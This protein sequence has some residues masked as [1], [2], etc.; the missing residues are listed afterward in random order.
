[1]IPRSGAAMLIVV[2]GLWAWSGADPLAAAA[3]DPQGAAG[4]VSTAT[5]MPTTDTLA[6]LVAELEQRNPELA[7]TRSVVDMRAAGIAPAGA[8]PDPV[9]TVGY[10][11]GFLRPPFFP[12][13]STPNAFRQVGVSQQLPY[14]GK[15]ALRANIARMEADAAR[16]TSEDTRV[17]LIA[18]LKTTYIEYVLIDRSLA[19]LERSR[20]TLV[21]FR[22]TAEAR[23]SLNKA[24]QQDVINAQLQLSIL[25]ERVTS[26]TRHKVSLQAEIN[27]LVYRPS[28]TPVPVEDLVDVRPL[29]DSIEALQAVANVR[30]PAIKR[31]E[32]G[33]ARE[34]QALALAKKE[35]LP[36]FAVSLTTQKFVGDMPWM[37][38]IDF[39]V[40][41]PI[42]SQR[43]QQPM[44]AQAVASLE[45]ATHTR[46]STQSDAAARVAEQCAAVSG[47]QRLMALYGDSVL[48]QARLALESS[49]SA[50]QVGTVDFLTVLTNFNAVLNY[51]I[52]YE[53]Q[54]A[55]LHQALALLEPLTGIEFIR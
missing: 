35:R 1:M 45:G 27:R 44:V 21:Q 39:M 41:V 34:Q 31:D 14:P 36:D 46:E 49:L 16:W 15:L 51:E 38:G 43:K 32:A 37:Y 5:S 23:Y 52:S 11:S 2:T 10:M 40:N 28:G 54:K 29:A 22:E 17:R 8:P 47:S 48:P 55:Q 3:P 20:T 26:L 42:F 7:A 50:Y 33:I 30:Y 12:S 6:T 18:D 25:T 24:S 9:V 13:S 53:E 4:Q 19:I